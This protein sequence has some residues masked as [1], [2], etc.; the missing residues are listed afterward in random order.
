[1]ESNQPPLTKREVRERKREE[2]KQ[3]QRQDA[4]RRKT[5]KMATWG[6]ATVAIIAGLWGIA[7]WAT[8]LA[9]AIPTAELLT[10]APDDWTK[11]D[12]NAKVTLVEYLDFECEACRAYY[13]T[14]KQILSEYGNDVRLVV[15]YFPLP[16]HKN[17]IPAALAAE[18][19]G[20]Q[21]KFWDMGDLLFD[22]QRE[23]GE[24]TKTDPSL[25]E[26]HAEK[27]GLDMVRFRA[28]VQAS[29][30]RTR[31]E[32]DRAAGQRLGISGTP[33]FFLNGN[34]VADLGSLKALVSQAVNTST[35][36]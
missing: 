2:R 33:S 25:F 20:K 18:A 11:G 16:G 12:P 21:G 35:S 19:A 7:Q 13:P 10:V 4:D 31:V 26:K 23:W 17:S 30:T 29:E 6:I 32:R 28:D 14:V 22:T 9:P 24:G 1:M 3:A 8:S 27:L 34:K 5:R 36:N 15:R